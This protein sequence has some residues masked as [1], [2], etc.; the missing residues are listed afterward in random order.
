MT[1]WIVAKQDLS[2]LCKRCGATYKPAQPVAI[3]MY[4]A[5]CKEFEKQH[6]D[7]TND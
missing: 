1:N 5:M 3:R 7:C 2:F 6:K 4:S